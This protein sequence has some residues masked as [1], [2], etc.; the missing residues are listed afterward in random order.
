MSEIRRRSTSATHSG[1][2]SSKRSLNIPGSCS[3]LDSI[4]LGALDNEDHWWLPPSQVR[5]DLRMTLTSASWNRTIL[6]FTFI[7]FTFVLTELVA[8]ILEPIYP[9][10][11]KEEKFFFGVVLLGSETIGAIMD[12]F[13]AAELWGWTL[14]FGWTWLL[15]LGNVMEVLVLCV[16]LGFRM[17][18]TGPMA[19]ARCFHLL[20]FLVWMS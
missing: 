12:M 3:L 13:L 20:V 6:L 16:D 18:Y 1:H 5:A 17:Q 19:V 14:A 9:P 15:D 2:L 7:L 11:T 4:P 8:T 10:S